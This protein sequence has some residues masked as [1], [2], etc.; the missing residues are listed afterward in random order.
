MDLVVF[1]EAFMLVCFGFSWPINLIKNIKLKS[2]KP[3][4]LPFTL[5]ILVGYIAGITKLAI[6]YTS[7]IY[8]EYIFYI[9]LINFIFVAANVFVYFYNRTL[10]AKRAKEQ[11]SEVITETAPVAEDAQEEVATQTANAEEVKENE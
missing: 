11:V 7:T 5:L 2:A 1:F 4:N 8:L 6:K 10:D 3:M 9:Y